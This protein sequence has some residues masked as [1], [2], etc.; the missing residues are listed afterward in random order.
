M[1][2]QELLAVALARMVD[3]GGSTPCAAA[4]DRL[5]LSDRAGDREAAVRLC[6]GCPVFA[7]CGEAADE[8]G[9]S[10]GVWGGRDRTGIPGMATQ[11]SRPGSRPLVTVPD[12]RLIRR[13]ATSSG[14][15]RRPLSPTRSAPAP[16]SSDA[17]RVRLT[18]VRRGGAA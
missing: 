10:F 14:V 12:R 4:G 6:N 17:S 9:E 7:E 1:T 11:V 8:V 16:T 15:I 3:D 5:W 13:D 2:A 18:P